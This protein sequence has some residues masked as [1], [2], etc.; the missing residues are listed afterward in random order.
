MARKRR[1]ISNSR[2]RSACSTWPSHARARCWFWA[3]D[4]RKARGVV[5]AMG[6]GT[7][8]EGATRRHRTGPA[9]KTTR[10]RFRSR[11]QDFSVEML[12]AAAFTRP[13][14]LPLNIDIATVNRDAA[15]RELPRA[16]SSIERRPP[17]RLSSVEM[18]PSD[19]A[20]LRVAFATFNGRACSALPS[21]A[22]QDP[23]VEQVHSRCIWVPWHTKFWSPAS[24]LLWSS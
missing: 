1:R 12:S 3:R 14:Q 18:T 22:F 5:A 16:D 20:A 19:L 7:L 11:G 10:V 15:F 23:R 8:R 4:S 6:G 9:G 2:K 13:E 21:P 17:R 24:N